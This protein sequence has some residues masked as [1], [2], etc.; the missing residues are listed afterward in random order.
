LKNRYKDK[1]FKEETLEML[2][3][4]MAAAAGAF[5]KLPCVQDL[6]ILRNILYEG[7]W[8]TFEEEKKEG[9]K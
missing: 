6:E 1:K 3:L 7:V 4:M 2:N 9:Q 8:T 5:E